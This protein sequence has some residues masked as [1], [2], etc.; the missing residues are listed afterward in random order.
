MKMETVSLSLF[1]CLFYSYTWTFT[2]V[3][4]CV[5]VCVH[6]CVFMYICMLFLCEKRRKTGS[7]SLSPFL[8]LSLPPLALPPSSHPGAP[9]THSRSSRATP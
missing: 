3:H 7:F 1:V 2:C 8:S 4:M 5:C 9:Q 6:V